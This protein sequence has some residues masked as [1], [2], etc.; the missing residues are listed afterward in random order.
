[1]TQKLTREEGRPYRTTFTLFF[2]TLLLLCLGIIVD[3]PLIFTGIGILIA[4]YQLVVLKNFIS[5]YYGE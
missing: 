5:S 2:P 1:M 3:D 4:F